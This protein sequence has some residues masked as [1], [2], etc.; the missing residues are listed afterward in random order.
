MS[1]AIPSR[2]YNVAEDAP[3]Q[4]GSGSLEDGACCCGRDTS[5]GR[6]GSKNAVR[7]RL[8]NTGCTCSGG[9]KRNQDAHQDS[10]C[11][12]RRYALPVC[13]HRLFLED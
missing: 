7:W 10:D 13:L 3:P 8:F 9:H 12:C 4:S 1:G 2:M 6:G 11:G 5:G